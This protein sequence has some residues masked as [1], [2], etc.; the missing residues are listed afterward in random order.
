MSSSRDRRTPAAAALALA[1]LLLSPDALGAPPRPAASQSKQAARGETPAPLP[2]FGSPTRPPARHRA[3]PDD[4][5]LSAPDA[6][7]EANGGSVRAV[8]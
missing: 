8:Y 2:V 7:R 3:A 6:A 4:D 5:V 1:A